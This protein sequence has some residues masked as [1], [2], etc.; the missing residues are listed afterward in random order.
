MRLLHGGLLSLHS[1]CFFMRDEAQEAPQKD[2]YDQRNSEAEHELVESRSDRQQVMSLLRK[3]HKARG[4]TSLANE[5]LWVGTAITNFCCA[6]RHEFRLVI[7]AGEEIP[8]PRRGNHSFF[9]PALYP[10]Q[11]KTQ[12]APEAAALNGQT[13][14]STMLPPL[15]GIK[16]MVCTSGE[17]RPNESQGGR[18]GM[19][20]EPGHALQ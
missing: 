2:S 8:H 10:K 11:T 5:N 20:P 17:R 7:R 18:A 3:P 13:L 16:F 15:F 12:F 4:M 9:E 6:Q 14:G 1:I 19:W